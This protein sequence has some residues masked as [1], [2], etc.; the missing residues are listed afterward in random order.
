MD[1]RTFKSVKLLLL[2]SVAMSMLTS[3]AFAEKEDWY[4]G[5]SLGHGSPKFSSTLG[6]SLA[7]AEGDPTYSTA[8]GLSSQI[9]FYWPSGEKGLLGVASGGGGKSFSSLSGDSST[10]FG[11]SMLTLSYIHSTGKE[12]GTGVT[13]RAGAGYGVS[14]ESGSNAL[15]FTGSNIG[16]GLRGG[17]GYG[18]SLSEQT[19][20]IIE[21]SYG[22]II[23]PDDSYFAIT[24]GPLF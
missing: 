4:W 9:H 14:Y 15:S 2:A 20:L 5:F 7:S 19:R 11:I 3:K 1:M 22:R 18:F 6:S 24:V 23:G 10:N 8:I 17:L 13:L 21:A 12:P 16:L